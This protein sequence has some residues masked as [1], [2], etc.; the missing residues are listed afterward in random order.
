MI[1]TPYTV[2]RR[3]RSSDGYDA[4]GNPVFVYSDPEPQPMHSVSGPG[5]DG[6]VGRDGELIDLVAFGPAGTDF[7][8]KDVGVWEGDEFDVEKVVDW[9]KGPWRNPVAGVEIHLRRMEG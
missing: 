1:P 3:R 6:P 8:T 2:G 7:T 5:A 9:T 4:H